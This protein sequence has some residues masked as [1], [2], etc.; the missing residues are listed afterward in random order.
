M[1][2]IENIKHSVEL[3]EVTNYV[4]Q[5]NCGTRWVGVYEMVNI[6]TKFKDCISFTRDLAEFI[7]S[8]EERAAILSLYPTLK[9]LNEVTLHLQMEGIEFHTVRQIMDG[10]IAEFDPHGQHDLA[11]K[12]GKQ[13]NIIHNV[14]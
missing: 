7:L 1:Q 13:S 9:N 10:V 5:I 3:R 14:L 8:G 11:S 4:P 12:I 2:E 6:Y